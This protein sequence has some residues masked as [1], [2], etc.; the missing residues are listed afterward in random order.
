MRLKVSSKDHGLC[1]VKNVVKKIM[2]RQFERIELSAFF[3]QDD[4][5]TSSINGLS[6]ASFSA[7]YALLMFSG[8]IQIMTSE[9]KTD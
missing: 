8:P 2:L 4:S 1:S 7:N 6:K 3:E 5:V 9:K